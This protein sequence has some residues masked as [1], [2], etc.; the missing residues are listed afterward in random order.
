MTRHQEKY[1]VRTT[2]R[3]AESALLG[4]KHS[5]GWAC[6]VLRAAW[7]GQGSSEDQ[8]GLRA[9]TI[10]RAE[11]TAPHFLARSGE[12]CAHWIAKA[13]SVMCSYAVIC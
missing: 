13:I 1:D 9:A 4:S 3:P 11:T 8:P 7:S 6:L 10:A 12:S 5:I 2:R